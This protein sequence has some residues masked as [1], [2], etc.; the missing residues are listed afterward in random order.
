MRPPLVVSK[1][2]WLKTSLRFLG[3]VMTGN[4]NV[5]KIYWALVSFC[6]ESI[7]NLQLDDR[8]IIAILTIEPSRHECDG[9]REVM[10]FND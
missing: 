4:L 6:S 7:S 8:R 5:S 10:T 9:S 2:V 3:L 1:E